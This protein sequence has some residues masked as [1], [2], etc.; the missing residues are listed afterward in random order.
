MKFGIDFSESRSD[1][2]PKNFLNF[3]SSTIEKQGIENL[4]SYS[5]KGD[6]EIAFLGEE[7]YAAFHSFHF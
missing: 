5:S 4:G 1:F 2:F 7:E 6:A 3:S